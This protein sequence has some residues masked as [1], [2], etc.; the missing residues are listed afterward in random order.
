MIETVKAS[1]QW[2]GRSSYLQGQELQALAA[3]DAS[4]E[5]QFLGL[6]FD[7]VITVGKRGN[8]SEDL[9]IASDQL[10][11]MQIDLAVV[12][13]GGQ[14]TLHSP[15][16]LVIYPII[17]LKRLRWSVKQYLLWLEETTRKTLMELDVKTTTGAQP[18]LYSKKGKIAFFGVRIHQG[19]TQHG[20]SINVSNDLELFNFIRSCGKE[21][22]I[23]D[24]VADS[25]DVSPKEVFK[26]WQR[27]ALQSLQKEFSQQILSL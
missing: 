18:G 24:R 3:E 19:V 25:S 6:E 21:G 23:F 2:R 15:G 4:V 11:E 22:E 9:L 14:A 12:D 10:A 27:I 1:F 26:C 5:M 17:S 7:T 16:Q 20:V 13:R 8:V